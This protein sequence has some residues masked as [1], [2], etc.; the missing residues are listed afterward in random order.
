M[1]TLPACSKLKYLSGKEEWPILQCE[2]VYILPGVPQFFEKKIGAL[3]PH[4][5]ESQHFESVS[6]KIVLSVDEVS[7]VSVLNE[8]VRK[9]PHVS[10]GSYPFVGHP[11]Y[12]TVVTL[13]A[14]ECEGPTRVARRRM[15]SLRASSVDGMNSEM[16]TST[17]AR[18]ESEFSVVFTEAEMELN[19]KQALNE[20]ISE[21]PENS[22]LRVDNDDEQLV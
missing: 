11:E 4:L 18:S 12:S 22:I 16:Q 5:A 15:S 7:V 19:M 10:I 8:V 21:L 20:L 3:A 2:N 17:I 9:H 14:H 6:C 1:A 13:E